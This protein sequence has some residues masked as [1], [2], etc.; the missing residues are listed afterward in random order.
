MLPH[1]IAILNVKGF[2]MVKTWHPYKE[3]KVWVKR[4]MSLC[5][6]LFL[7]LS[8]KNCTFL[9]IMLHLL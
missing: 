9:N 6:W 2:I 8:C 5:Y 3:Q 4:A 1:I 7:C